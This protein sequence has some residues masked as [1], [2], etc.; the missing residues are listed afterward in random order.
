MSLLLVSLQLCGV[1]AP[2]LSVRRL[3]TDVR[4][5]EPAWP[6]RHLLMAKRRTPVGASHRKALSPL[7]NQSTV[8]IQRAWSTTTVATRTSATALTS[9]FLQVTV[10]KHP[11][12]Y[13]HF[14]RPVAVTDLD[15][16]SLFVVFSMCM[17][18]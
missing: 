16:C 3:A 7:D 10:G 13:D 4:Q 12:Q 1:T 14:H 5:M 8:G 17:F 18:V 6:P 15:H 2:F 11:V 9:N